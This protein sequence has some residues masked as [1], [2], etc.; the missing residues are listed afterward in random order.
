[1]G[2]RDGMVGVKGWWSQGLGRSR[3]GGGQ[4]GGG[5]KGWGDGRWWGQENGV[6]RVKGGIVEV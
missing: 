3:C 5:V 2:S 4:G 6:V 1:M